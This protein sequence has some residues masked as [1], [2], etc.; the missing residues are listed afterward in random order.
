MSDIGLTQNFGVFISHASEDTELVNSFAKILRWNNINPLVAEYFTEPGFLLWKDKIK[1]LIN[2]CNYFVVLYT[3]N[4]Q[5]KVKVHQEIG[6]AGIKEKR[7]I[8]LL[9][10]GI[11]RRDLPGYLEG[12]EIV[13]NFSPYNPFGAFNNITCML[14]TEWYE[15][16]VLIRFRRQVNQFYGCHETYGKILFKYDETAESWTMYRYDTQMGKYVPLQ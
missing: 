10:E 8:V 3:H 9:Q 7:I 4:A 14:L 16:A 12:L 15:N 13:E 2:Q 6:S 5:N 1:R 11:D